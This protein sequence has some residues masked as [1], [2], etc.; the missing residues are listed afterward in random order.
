MRVIPGSPIVQGALQ[1]S[2]LAQSQLAQKMQREKLKNLPQALQAQ[3]L[4]QQE[5]AKQAQMKSQFM[6]QQIQAA[7]AL[8][9]AQLPQIQAQT[10]LTKMRAQMM[11][12]QMT[13]AEQNALNKQ[14]AVQQSKSRFN[15]KNTTVRAMRNPLFKGL[16]S[17]NTDFANSVNRVIAGTA[18]AADNKVVNSM[19]DQFN[20]P[21]DMSG[22][23]PQNVPD[24]SGLTAAFQQ[25]IGRGGAPAQ[26]TS[27][28]DQVPTPD[29]KAQASQML[30]MTTPQ[31]QELQQ[32]AGSEELKRATTGRQQNAM[33]AGQIAENMIKD[34][35]PQMDS[36]MKYA[37]ASGLS[38]K[39]ANKTLA[40][41]DLES[42]DYDKYYNFMHTTVP[43]LAAKIRGLSMAPSTNQEVNAYLHILENPSMVGKKI[44]KSS[45]NNLVGTLKNMEKVEAQPLLVAQQQLQQATQGS[46]NGATGAPTIPEFK[47]KADFQGYYQGLN[48]Q[49]QAQ[50]RAQLGK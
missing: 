4:M 8:Q 33:L 13:I 41:F 11:P 35:E 40:P 39:I 6:P 24:T 29:Q 2:Q 46:E 7:L 47:T 21:G 43:T 45:W 14:L 5:A 42:D 50:V 3:L 44:W 37:G 28:L 25:Q 31:T 48:P 32:L 30:G 12:Q 17:K 36:I 38:K 19:M 20:V 27:T 18:S 34:V 22:Q 23:A 16:Y 26:A 1:G 10:D 15:D 9:Q 49:Q